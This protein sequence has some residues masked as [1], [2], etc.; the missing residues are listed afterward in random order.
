[1]S[2]VCAPTMPISA[3]PSNSLEAEDDYYKMLLEECAK[4]CVYFDKEI[5]STPQSVKE[6]NEEV[7]SQSG[8]ETNESKTDNDSDSDDSEEEMPDDSDDDG[9]GGYNEYGE[10]DRGYYYRDGRYERKVSPMMSPI[11]SPVT[12]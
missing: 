6:T 4:D 8:G 3:G 5:D 2:E 1:M 7:V 9:Y 12:A 10:C 11:I